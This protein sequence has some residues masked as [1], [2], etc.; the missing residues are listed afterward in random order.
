[1]GPSYELR[2]IELMTEIR[3]DQ[4]RLLR[5]FEEARPRVVPKG[6]PK[7]GELVDAIAAMAGARVFTTAE[8]IVHAALPEASALRD[9]IT[10]LVGRLNAKALGKA[11]RRCEGADFAG[12]SIQRVGDDR[13]GVLWR[14]SRLTNPKTRVV[15][16]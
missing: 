9:A 7:A 10:A 11:L 16:A 14:V 6:D 1:M 4:R 2:L 3:D 5:L 13:G 8:L 15:G 12:L